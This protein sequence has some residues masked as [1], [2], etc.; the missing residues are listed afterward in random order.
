MSIFGSLFKKEKGL[1]LSGSMCGGY[2]TRNE[3]VHPV[4]GI[5]GEPSLFSY[6][7]GNE[8]GNMCR[9]HTIGCKLGAGH[10]L[11]ID[12]LM[13][14]GYRTYTRTVDLS[15]EQWKKL[16]EFA[17]ALAGFNG[18]CVEVNG[19]PICGDAN[20]SIE[21]TSGEKVRFSFN[22]GHAP[23]GWSE[24]HAEFSEWLM[25]ISEYDESK[26]E[27][28]PPYVS[29]Y[30]GEHR[31]TAASDGKL[32]EYIVLI[33]K[34]GFD[35][36]CEFTAK[37]DL[38]N[39]HIRCKATKVTGSRLG[40]YYVSMIDYFD[41]SP[42]KRPFKPGHLLAIMD[43]KNEKMIIKPTVQISFGKDIPFERIEYIPLKND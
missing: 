32:E 41:D 27:K 24:V 10:S 23:A 34:I 9:Y 21:F 29:P 6:W 15:Q 17:F 12:I 26:C 13:F 1:I 33:K 19:L 42:Q 30:L 38:G 43:Y 2:R 8:S 35:E 7:F 18:W 22:G 4:T 25:E 31:F 20:C 28:L 37:G 14:T 3:K 11:K 5:D 39:V 36:N 16:T 40:E